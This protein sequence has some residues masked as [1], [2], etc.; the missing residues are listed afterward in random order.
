[1]K[2]IILEYLVYVDSHLSSCSSSIGLGALPEHRLGVPLC[3]APF[4]L[5]G[6]GREG[7]C[8]T[9][10]HH[11]AGHWRLLKAI[12]TKENTRDSLL[13]QPSSSSQA[14]FIPQNTQML[15]R[16]LPCFRHMPS[17]PSPSASLSHH[18]PTP[19]HP[20]HPPQPQPSSLSWLTQLTQKAVSCLSLRP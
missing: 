4:I 12:K 1:M 9:L 10:S 16:L 6:E 2:Y 19:P 11:G 14:S 18:T 5:A 8:Q 13:E 15:Q 17:L 20:S 3:L 7:M